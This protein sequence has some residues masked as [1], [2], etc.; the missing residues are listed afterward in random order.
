MDQRIIRLYDEYT[1]APLPRRVFLKRLATLTGS[2]AAATALLPLL[3]N[4]YAQASIVAP[5]DERI[6]TGVVSYPTDNGDIAA[7]I[8]MPKAA[9][10]YPAVLVIHENRGLNP[11][12]RDIARRLAVDGFLAM[13]PDML[14][15][16]GGTPEDQDKA[17]EM[18]GEL[19][20]PT[21]V[22]GLVAGADFLGDHAHSTGKVG[23]VGFCWGG[24]MANWVAVHKPDLLAAVPFYGRQPSAEDAA[25]IKAKLQLHYAGMDDRVNAGIADYEA[26]LKNAGVDYELHIYEGANHAFNNDT[27]EARYHPEAAKLAWGRTVDF[28][29]ANLG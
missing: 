23:C 29:K 3:E 9:G 8:A 18:I 28:L 13:A 21:T 19:N 15:S 1:H 24:A 16:M 26:A 6:S 5:N 20:G 2:T 17:R 7:F 14:S 27:N 25:M 10:K 4:N 12:I 11:H 22:R